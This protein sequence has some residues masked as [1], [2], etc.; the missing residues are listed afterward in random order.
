MI[1][2]FK[3]QATEDIYNGV[4]SKL[5]RK[6]CPQTIWR[7]AAR[8]LDQLDSVVALEELRIPPGNRL[9]A[10]S[11]NR[12]GEFSIRINEQYRICFKWDESGP[13]DVEVTD[14]H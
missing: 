1:V 13:Y 2:S 5:A 11:G 7:I 4:G 8:K 14:Y 12:K 10:L 3:D 6:A 9:E